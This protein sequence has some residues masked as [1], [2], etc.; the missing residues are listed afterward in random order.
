MQ[1]IAVQGLRRYGY[2]EEADRI[3]INFLSMV[4]KEFVEHHTVVE[5]YDVRQRKSEVDEGIQYGYLSNERGFGW[6]NAVF[7]RLYDELPKSEK[8]QIYQ[9]SIEFELIPD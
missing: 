4:L 9:R 7:E 6:T 1:L 5:K 3:S 2:R 8:E